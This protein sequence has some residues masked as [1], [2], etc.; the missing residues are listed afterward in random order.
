VLSRFDYWPAALTVV[1]LAALAG[2]HRRWA[3]LAV[4]AAFATKVY[5]GVLLP[6]LLA[7]AWRQR[8]RAE[9]LRCAGL[10]AAAAL[11]FFLPFLAVAP[12][13][14]WVSVHR[15]TGRPL[16]VETLGSAVL[17]AA[18]HLF[19]LRASIVSSFGSQNLATRFSGA[20]A[21]LTTLLQVGS[22][23]AIW[24]RYAVRWTGERDQLI[25]YGIA[26]VAA[27][28]AFGKVL[29][30]QFMIW[31]I[32][33]VPLV[34]G[35]RGLAACA[36]LG[37]ALV[38]TQLWFPHHY[39]TLVQTLAPRYTTLILLRDLALVALALLLV[40]PTGGRSAATRT[41]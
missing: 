18:H 21:T 2:G 41:L 39:W 10:A 8:G 25:R 15:Q 27:F 6:I 12:H 1:A 7:D 28:M 13:G 4:G 40:W 23:L 22:L 3:A 9:A 20:A 31:L 17:L 24:V 37:A 14:V 32:P 11:L 34:A 33:L 29:S 5:P 38:L 16:Q 26:S 35:R 36:L 19:D 30:P